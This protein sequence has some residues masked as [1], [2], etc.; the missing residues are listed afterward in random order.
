[1]AEI[2]SIA[3]ALVI[4]FLAGNF[5]RET[6]E[7]IKSVKSALAAKRDKPVEDSNK[8]TLID[9][10]DPVAEAKRRFKE[11]MEDLNPYE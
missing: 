1:M 9:P 8:S 7:S 3:I 6:V 5:R 2:L 11:Q 4:G 10:L